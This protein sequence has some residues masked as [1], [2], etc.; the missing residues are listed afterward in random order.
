MH[1][2][3]VM[4]FEE[5]EISQAAIAAVEAAGGTAVF[6]STGTA[7]LIDFLSALAEDEKKEPEAPEEPAEEPAPPEEPA[8][9]PAPPEE[10]AKAPAPTEEPVK[11][12]SLDF[13]KTIMVDDEEI[14][15]QI[16]ENSSEIIL[17]V[18]G[19][20][21]GSNGG[22]SY[23]K[24]NESTYWTWGSQ[25]DVQSQTFQITIGESTG[26]CRVGIVKTAPAGQ[27]PSAYL[28]IGREVYDSIVEA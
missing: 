14:P 20:D 2:V 13:S 1:P 24:L 19:F 25:D 3:L 22:R 16:I 8:K 11:K 12:E 9:A 23:F 21:T 10:P 4:A 18:N 26:Y 7:K 17:Y 6:L 27:S 28:A 5:S 15:M